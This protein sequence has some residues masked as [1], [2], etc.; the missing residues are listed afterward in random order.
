MKD[1]LDRFRLDGR[2]KNRLPWKIWVK[3]TFR[4]RAFIRQEWLLIGK[5]KGGWAAACDKFGVSIPG[6]VK[7]HA[8]GQVID[9]SDLEGNPHALARNTVSYAATRNIDTRAT[10]Y[11]MQDRRAALERQLTALAERK[12]TL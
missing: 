6:W 9:A 8:S 7:R 2:V 12:I 1:T 4:L 10:L 3:R 11:A 5:L